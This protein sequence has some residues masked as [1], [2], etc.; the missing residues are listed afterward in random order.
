MHLANPRCW[1]RLDLPRRPTNY[2]LLDLGAFPQAEMQATLILRGESTA[3]RDLLHLHLP[4]PGQPHLCA[5]GAAVAG[6]AFQGKGNPLRLLLDSRVM[7]VPMASNPTFVM[8][9]FWK[10]LFFNSLKNE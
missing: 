7:E 8:L 9:S 6:A 1:Q 5:N 3:T 10:P 4:I 2:H